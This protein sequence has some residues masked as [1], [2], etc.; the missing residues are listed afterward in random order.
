[1]R[2]TAV[3]QTAIG[4]GDPFLVLANG[5]IP[6]RIAGYKVSPT[7]GGNPDRAW[8]DTLMSGR[9][10]APRLGSDNQT[11]LRSGARAHP[12]AKDVQSKSGRGDSQISGDRT[13]M[14][15]LKGPGR[16]IS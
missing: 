5:R 4:R 12:E 15:A 3:R 8:T 2:K 9:G 16:K 7:T 11:A 6:R 10:S 14:V 13:N 1:M